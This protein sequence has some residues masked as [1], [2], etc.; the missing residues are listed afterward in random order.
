MGKATHGTR[1]IEWHFQKKDSWRRK[2]SK[3]KTPDT[4]DIG[5]PA[6]IDPQ[7]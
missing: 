5:L 6:G 7:W 3:K 1:D 4:R 2:K